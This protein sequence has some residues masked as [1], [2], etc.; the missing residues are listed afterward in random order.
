MS[1]SPVAAANGPQSSRVATPQPRGLRRLVASASSLRPRGHQSPD[2]TAESGPTR[3]Q[4]ADQL[5][6]SKV[7]LRKLRRRIASLEAVAQPV[8]G[9]E[10]PNG[11]GSAVFR[12][13]LRLPVPP[14]QE[15]SPERFPIHEIVLQTHAKTY[16]P[17]LLIEHG[18]SRYEDPALVHLMTVLDE[19]GEG[20]FLDIGANI[21]PYALMCAALT[22]RTTVAFEPTP[23]LAALIRGSAFD[24][25]L[26][27]RVEHVALGESDGEASLFLSDV[28][29]TSSS[30]N[31]KW[32]PS[33]A[34]LR[35]PVTSVD[36]YCARTDTSP[37]VLKIDTETT[38]PD[39]LRGA[40]GIVAEHRPWIICE[41][42]AG[43][44]GAGP[45][46]QDVVSDWGYSYY[47]LAPGA[48]M[49]ARTEITG[50]SDHFM[51]LFAPRQLDEAYRRRF[52]AWRGAFARIATA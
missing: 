35:V 21:G 32:R 44:R 4:L 18:L 10:G 7:E 17:R 36:S 48:E 49:E 19:A 15:G 39:V 42:L 46:V 11:R 23:E 8:A 38:E 40:A 5:A 3:Q 9:I 30:L 25:G 26:D 33:H 47:H 20:A 52:E 16:I 29:D 14:P 37:A 27:V 24:N 31:P 51:W 50:D 13:R 43:P 1:E 28:T 2:K 34:S 45:Q 12:Y 22:D 41:V 6:A